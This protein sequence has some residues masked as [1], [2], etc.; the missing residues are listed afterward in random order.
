MY[1]VYFGNRTIFLTTQ[2]DKYYKKYNGLFVKYL[3]E[4]QLAYVMELFRNIKE[5]K[6]VFIIHY[7][8]EKI[9]NEFKTFFNLVE[10][11]GGLVYNSKGQVLV[12]RRRGLW[13]LPKGKMESGES[14]DKCAIREVEEECSIDSLQ[15]KD[16]LDI[17]YHSYF[18]EGSMMLKKTYWY[19]MHHEG[20]SN[21]APQTEEDITEV[22]WVDPEDLPEI[23]KNTYPSIVDVLKAGELF[24]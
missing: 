7:D 5:I 10:A 12:I 14:P 8:L 3:N 19:K 4:I 9:F 11:A 17:T 2:F 24:N 6:N 16:L 21:L 15:I 1:K 13:D 18:Q 20:E 23:T 22:K